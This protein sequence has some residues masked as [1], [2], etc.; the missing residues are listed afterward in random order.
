MDHTQKLKDQLDKN[1]PT[2]FYDWATGEELRVFA[3][4][5]MTRMATT[6]LRNAVAQRLFHPILHASIEAG[7]MEEV[8]HET[9]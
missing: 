5:H 3:R 7:L 1:V 4:E 9:L 6:N 8:S 2:W